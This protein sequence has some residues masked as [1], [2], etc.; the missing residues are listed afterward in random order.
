[1]TYGIGTFKPLSNQLGLNFDLT[2]THLNEGKDWTNTLNM[3]SKLKINGCLQIT[4]LIELFGGGSVN[5][6]ASKLI[7][8]EGNLTGSSLIP[9]KGFYKDIIYNTHVKMFF[10]FNAG[11]RF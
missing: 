11:I 3:V 7:D 4:E 10:G 6:A 1:M 8:N 2:A 9:K 5:F